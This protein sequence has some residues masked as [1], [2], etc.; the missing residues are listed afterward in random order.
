MQ[1]NTITAQNDVTSNANDEQVNPKS[2]APKYYV[3][4]QS[5]YL[6]SVFLYYN[7]NNIKTEAKFW[8][9]IQ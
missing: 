2:M 8:I 5:N 3:Q 4:L 7:L 9:A 6:G 1:N